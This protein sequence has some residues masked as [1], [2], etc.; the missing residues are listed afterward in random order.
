[1][2]PDFLV[3]FT[4]T[5]ITKMYDAKAA[6]IR[7]VGSGL[8]IIFTAT[9]YTKTIAPKFCWRWLRILGMIK[10]SGEMEEINIAYLT[11]QGIYAGL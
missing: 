8:S 3:G 6:D 1:M 2:G 4:L 5:Q 7:E 10:M 9:A 11:I